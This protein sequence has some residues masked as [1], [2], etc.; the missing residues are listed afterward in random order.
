MKKPNKTH[1]DKND[2][3]SA[4]ERGFTAIEIIVVITIIGILAT[5]A[6]VRFNSVENEAINAAANRIISDIAYAQEMAKL[7]FKGTQIGFYSA[8]GGGGGGGGGCFVATACYGSKSYQVNALRGF[9][10]QVLQKSEMGRSFI[11]WYYREGPILAEIIRHNSILRRAAQV[12]ILP[13]AILAMPFTE[14]AVAGG[15]GGGGGG[16]SSE[17]EPNT[18]GVRFQDGSNIVNPT[19][20][21]DYGDNYV[22]DLGDQVQITSADI[23]LEFDSSGKLSTPGTSWSSSQSSMV[24]VT[25]NSTLNIRIARHT[26]KAWIE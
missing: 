12:A 24:I 18:Y 7:E 22:V 3:R 20:G 15:G 6:I 10:D 4:T 2:V 8:G 21:D 14:N 16:G 1:S 5:V 11:K 26:G 9:R 13:L 17:G 19:T 25:L 23:T